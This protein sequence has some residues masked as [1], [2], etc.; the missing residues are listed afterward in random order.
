MSAKVPAARC[1][2]AVCWPVGV[3]ATDWCTPPWGR[4]QDMSYSLPLRVYRLLPPNYNAHHRRRQIA[5]AYSLLIPVLCSFTST[6]CAN[7]AKNPTPRPCA[8]KSVGT[9]S[10]RNK[11]IGMVAR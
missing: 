6:P 10:C 4:T 1:E 8:N 11:E 5:T 7:R 9:H 3:R 2:V